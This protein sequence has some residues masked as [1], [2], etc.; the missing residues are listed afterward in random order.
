[1][2]TKSIGIKAKCIKR[3]NLFRCIAG[4]EYEADRT[5]LL[6][7]YKDL[8]YPLIEY[9]VIIHAGACD[10]TLKKIKT[11]QNSFLRI[12]LGVMKTS[13]ISSLYVEA[14]IPPLSLRRMERSLCYT[15]KILFQPHHSTFKSLHVLPSSTIIM[16]GLQ[17]NG[18]V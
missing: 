15:S 5:T 4:A 2:N 16:S 13:P 18:R 11:I 14:C 9:G 3:L 6:H 7:L 1:M 12:A 8:V 10:N 17:R